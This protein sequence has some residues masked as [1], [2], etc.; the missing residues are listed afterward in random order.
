[1]KRLL[2]ASAALLLTLVC[3]RVLAQPTAAAVAAA[4]TATTDI[5]AALVQ[6]AAVPG[7]TMLTLIDPARR[8]LIPVAFYG[9]PS[10]GPRPL[11]VISHGWGGKNTDYGFIAEALVARGFA[12][13]SL[14]Q[15]LPGDPYL[16]GEGNIYQ[17]RLPIW[18]SGANNILYVVNE[19]RRQG[20]ADQA[21]PVVLVGHSNGGDSSMLFARQNPG[22][23]RAVYTMDSRRMPFP[24][25]PQPRICSIRSSNFEADPGVIPEEAEQLRLGM[26]IRRVPIKHE[27]M[28]D[29]AAPE[30]K[31]IMLDQLFACLGG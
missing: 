7:P 2:A 23:T 29:G 9:G 24:R 10:G 26:Q 14:Q 22:M 20:V 28:W 16:T 12:V 30:Q 1:M 3:G 19:L 18:Q 6:A 17:A 4:P 11:A 21:R 31:I 5:P 25:V 8:R 13:A 27:E 15:W